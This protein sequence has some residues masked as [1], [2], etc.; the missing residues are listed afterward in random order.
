[1][2]AVPAG[3]GVVIVDDN[4]LLCE[5]LERWFSRTQAVRCLGC[6]RD[7][8][9]AMRMIAIAEPDVVLL[10]VSMPG[11]E[12][13]DLLR[14]IAGQFTRVRVLMLSG[15][16]N[17]SLIDRAL[18]AGAAGYIVKDEPPQ[19]I[20]A[21]IRRAAEGEVVLSDLVRTVLNQGARR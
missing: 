13:F 7:T 18:A 17:R 11:G 1:M 12:S 10:D 16:A 6:A 21:C 9:A 5:A 19:A 3:I 15:L 14:W 4:E 2:E 20:I 8:A